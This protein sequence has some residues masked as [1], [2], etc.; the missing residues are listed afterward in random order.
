[1]QAF[2]FSNPLAPKLQ[3]LNHS[4]AVRQ[5]KYPPLHLQCPCK[6]CGLR[7]VFSKIADKECAAFFMA[8]STGMKWASA[9][10]L[11]PQADTAAAQAVADIKQKLGNCQPDVAFLFVS[12]QHRLN[13]ERIRESVLKDLQPRHLLGCSGGG[14]IGDGREAEQTAA[15]SLTAALL[16]NV[17]IKGFRLE[18]GTLPDLDKGPSQ[19]EDATGVAAKSHPHFVLLADPYSMLR[20]DELLQGLDFAYPHS[21]KIGGMASAANGPGQNVLFLDDQVYKSGAI[22]LAFSGELCVDPLVAQGCR[23]IGKVMRISKS[24]RNILI[25]LDKRK[26]LEVLSEIH[27]QS[28]ETDQQLIRT[29][30]FLGVVTDPFKQ[31]E[32]NAGD[33]LVRRLIGMDVDRGA[34]AIAAMLREG[35]TVQFHLFDAQA[36]SDELSEILRGYSR[37]HLNA[38]KG[39]SLPPPPR[40]AL[41][42]S[43]L[44]RGMQLYGR[45]DHDTGEFKAQIGEVPL[46]GFFC[47]GE[48]GPVAGASHI[49]G[50]TSSFAIF[51]SK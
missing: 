15:I 28:N 37:E 17:E 2:K 30:L 4:P 10:S 23:P 26:A 25:E 49:H 12:P 31:E 40:G 51:R 32:P 38:A 39:E 46:G 34:L 18:D 48:I 35:Q 41:L 14:I 13:Y 47:N 27:A 7:G 44:G 42:F 45:P 8:N 11:D 29:S 24:H 19:W 5:S 21:A 1:M 50:F 33:F 22:C 16:P 36:A 20:A 3:I 6:A 43:C 9:L